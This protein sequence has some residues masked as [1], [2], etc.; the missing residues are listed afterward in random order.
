M[1]RNDILLR[2]EELVRKL[3]EQQRRLQSFAGEIPA[4]EN[5]LLQR[6]VRQLYELTLELEKHRSEPVVAAP[7]PLVQEHV[8]PAEP[9][10]VPTATPAI[11]EHE[12]PAEHILVEAA[13]RAEAAREAVPSAGIKAPKLKGEVNSVLFKDN[14][15]IGDRFEDEPSIHERISSAH[16]TSSIA[17]HQQ[18]KAIPDLRKAIG[19]NEKFLFINHLFDGNLQVYNQAIEFIDGAAGKDAAL[20]YVGNTLIPQF[21]WDL[22]SQPG[23]LFLDLVERRFVK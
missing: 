3:D 7:A 15:T 14:P 17:N 19:L 18:R 10:A 12:S 5:D 2:I 4:L 1:S 20:D 22:K 11:T 9:E 8:R 13:N 6:Q 16:A 23:L 21:G